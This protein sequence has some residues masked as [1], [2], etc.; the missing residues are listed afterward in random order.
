MVQLGRYA[1]CETPKRLWPSSRDEADEDFH[2]EDVYRQLFNPDLYLRAYG[3]IYRERR[4]AHRGGHA[5]RPWTGCPWR[6]SRRS[7][8][9]SVMNVTDGPRCDG[10]TSRR[11]NGK[12]RPLGIPT[13]SDKLL[14]EVMRSLLEAYYEPQFSDHS[15]GF[16]PG[17]GC[18]TALQDIAQA[19][20]G[21]KWFI[22][23]DIKGCFDNIDHEIL[24]SILREKIHDNRFLIRLVENM[25]KAGYLEQWELPTHAQRHA[26]GRDRQ[27]LAREYLPGQARQATSNRRSS[28]PTRRARAKKLNPEYA[29]LCKKRSAR[30]EEGG[31]GDLP[32]TGPCLGEDAHAG[33]LTTRTIAGSSTCA[34]PTTSSSASRDRKR[35]AEA[36]K[37]R[38]GDV[39][40][41]SSQAGTVPGEDPDHPRRD[42]K[43]AVP[44]LR[45]HDHAETRLPAR[46]R[47]T[48][49]VAARSS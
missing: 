33:V 36:I 7:S 41:R 21:T 18:D 9:I 48:G 19:W 20:K 25:L 29:R 46:S 1:T 30:Q 4:C 35:E 43:G 45:D 14:Q 11:S 40:A 5:R 42:R 24:L 47:P 39:P 15:H 37:D 26:A 12:M 38:S 2:L 13:W 23:G 27:P 8:T 49:R 3:R 6:R 44:R 22:E 16:R 28:R 32:G 17:L 10:C 31:H 34:M